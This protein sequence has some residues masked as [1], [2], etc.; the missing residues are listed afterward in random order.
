[1][2]Q[3]VRASSRHLARLLDAQPEATSVLADLDT[4][5]PIR[6][7]DTASL[8]R[9]KALEHLRIA[10]RDLVGL[11]GMR[12][13][14]RALSHLGD[15]V[16]RRASALAGADDLVVVAM[17]KLGAR[18]VN[19]AS[20]LD[21]LFV[22]EGRYETRER[23]ARALLDVAGR[24]F[25]IDTGLRPEGR[26]GPLVRSLESYEAYWDRWAEPWE[27]QALLK[28]RP[29]CGPDPL[30]AAFTAAAARRVWDRPV[31]ADDIRAIR[32][33][34]ERA[35]AEVARRG[36]EG[37]EL[38]RGRGGIRDVEFAVQLLQLVHG[39]ADP[40]LRAPATLDALDALADGGYVADGDAAALA[41]A[42][43]FLRTVEHRLQLEDDQQVHT[44]PADPVARTRLARVLGYRSSPEADDLA[45]FD[46][47]LA[48]RQAA[49]RRIHEQLWWRPLLEAYG[50]QPSGQ[51]TDLAIAARLA[52]FGFSDAERTRQAVEALTHG[53]RRTSRLMQQSLPLLLGWLSESPDPDLGLL[54][55]RN[56]A[57][58]PRAQ[59]L[60]IAFRDSADTARRACLLL[61]TSRLLGEILEH[62]PDLVPRLADPERLRTAPAS[63]LAQRAAKAV[64]WR[65][66]VPERQDAARRW[67]QR[68]LLG[69]AA[70]DVMGAADVV[71]VGRD[72]TAVAEAT[73]DAALA[74]LDPQVPFA[75]LALGRFGGGE[76]SYA[77]DLDVIFVFDG[78]DDTGSEEHSLAVIEAERVATE[79]LR[80]VAGTTPSARIYDMDAD[81]R[82]EGKQ[83]LL[84][85]SVSGFDAYYDRWAQTWERQAMTR[86]RPAAGDQALGRHLL[87]VLDE[88]V[89]QPLLPEHEREIRRMKARVERERLPA[90]EDADF[91]LKLGKGGLTDVEWTAQLLQLR[92]GV[93]ATGTVEALA[94][95]E[96]SA[97]LSGE[98][99][100]ALSRAYRFCEITR[101][102]LL[103]VT[104]G[105]SDAL[106]QQ[107]ERLLPLARSLGTTAADLREEYRRVTRR[108]RNVVD[109]L[110]YGSPREER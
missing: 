62:E 83:G 51:L 49:V 98:D 26:D 27:F 55:L 41:E 13:T 100:A 30:Q 78:G 18:E 4:P 17:G 52:A 87:S 25:R 54:G 60:A 23:E 75:V 82:P 79:L 101:N 6:G 66:E 110:F 16:L 81:L 68:N 92:H 47:E 8:E 29:A 35:E 39:G 20:D 91:H 31:A 46:R 14:T 76:L 86:A 69:I 108:C 24:C 33:M 58:G 94:R 105:P 36:L 72:L 85:R 74:S 70:R 10:A 84:A 107:P 77:S 37:R 50:S 15:E 90:G 7:V 40:T 104:G 93:R 22:G 1:V 109:R 67:K 12:A 42:Y 71:D 97:H 95:L 89:W 57:S 45:A 88:R 32:A 63:E 44:V 103:L 106:P 3:I 34:K 5:V 9:E 65:D 73:L 2:H 64:T 43:T 99:A 53:L 96:D 80:F 61:G 19:Y 28:A 48:Q 21:V 56:L 38:K 11:D 102:R 59:Q